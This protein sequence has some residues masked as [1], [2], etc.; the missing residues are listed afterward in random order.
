MANAITALAELEANMT[1]R[2]LADWRAFLFASLMPALAAT[3]T[4]IWM[5]EAYWAAAVTPIGQ[6]AVLAC[7]TALITFLSSL[8]VARITRI[9]LGVDAKPAHP[10]NIATAPNDRL[11]LLAS[12]SLI[13]L[14]GGA[15]ILQA[16]AGRLVVT[17]FTVSGSDVI[18]RPLLAII[19]TAIILGTYF[20]MGRLA[21]V[22]PAHADG[23]HLSLP[24]L[25]QVSEGKA[26]GLF[27][28]TIGVPIGAFAIVA[29]PALWWIGAVP[30]PKFSDFGAAAAIG[31]ALIERVYAVAPAICLGFLASW[32][33]MGGGLAVAWQA[34]GR[35]EEP[36]PATPSALPAE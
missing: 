10:M 4:F 24:E 18:A 12:F 23:H 3:A 21:L 30:W 22:Y 34:Y 15:A 6:M 7:A 16:F 36:V 11:A 25:W 13:G 26:A 5:I 17:A 20:V 27:L 35:P 2:L 19:G 8:A 1:H 32:A 29:G 33:L 14:V 31:T 9:Q 28:A